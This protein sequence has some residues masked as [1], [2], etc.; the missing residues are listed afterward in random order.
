MIHFTSN[1]EL[2]R[3]WSSAEHSPLAQRHSLVK[4]TL[5]AAVLGLLTAGFALT[6]SVEIDPDL[7]AYGDPVRGV[8]GNIKSVGSDTMNN[9]MTLWAEGFKSKYPNVSGGSSSSP[10]RRGMTTCSVTS[11]CGRSSWGAGSGS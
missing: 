2:R 4:R 7:P 6:Q 3:G 8:S 5:H 1:A 11:V 10:S 9:L